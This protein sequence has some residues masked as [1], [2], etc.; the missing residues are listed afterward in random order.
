M[1]IPVARLRVLLVVGVAAAMW[2]VAAVPAADADA[3][4]AGSSGCGDQQLE[5]PFAPFG[6]DASYVLV[7]GGSFEAGG[8]AWT[9][10]A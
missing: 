10:T 5:Q 2:L 3:L 1:S 6:D 8:P 4:D 9:T 7:P